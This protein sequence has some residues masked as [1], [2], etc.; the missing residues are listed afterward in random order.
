MNDAFDAGR[1]AHRVERRLP[2]E[3]GTRGAQPGADAIVVT[4][5]DVAHDADDHRERLESG[6]EK[7]RW[8]RALQL[9]LRQLEAA[10]QLVEAHADGGRNAARLEPS[11]ARTQIV[12]ERCECTFRELARKRRLARARVGA[13]SNDPE[14]RLL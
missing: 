7:L 10:R 4:A 9:L 1:D 12:D 14:L 8:R 3:L 13:A 6:L 5:E 11:A 2:V